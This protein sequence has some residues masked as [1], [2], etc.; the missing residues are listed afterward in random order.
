M[1]LEAE[2][3]ELKR[4][5]G[6]LEGG[7]GFLTGQLR[8]VHAD[9]LKFQELTEG[10]FDSVDGRLDRL[11][12]DVGELK[13]DVRVLKVDVGL[14]KSDLGALRSELPTI[15]GDVMREVLREQRT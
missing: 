8:S 7:W 14:L 12:T 13:V 10:R 2:I 4:R 9:L 3:R 1:N 6:E 5:V 11:E 15:V